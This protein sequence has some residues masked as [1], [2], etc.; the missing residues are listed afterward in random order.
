MSWARVLATGCGKTSYRLQ[1]EGLG[2][3]FVTDAALERV[4]SGATTWRIHGLKREALVGGESADP[5]HAELEQQTLN[6]RIV[7]V[8]A[9]VSA[10]VKPSLALAYR[11][12]ITTW[13][14]A[15]LSAS[16]TAIT[17]ESTSGLANGDIIH[18]GTEAILIGTV[19]SS[20]SLTGCTRGR[21]N[22]IAQK[23]VI[24][25]GETRANPQVTN[26]PLCIEGRRAWLFAYG[27]S[28]LT[29]DVGYGAG[30]GT[31][32]WIGVCQTDARLVG[33]LTEWEIQ[34][35]GIWAITEQALGGEIGRPMRPRGV[36][37]SAEA[38]LRYSIYQHSSATKPTFATAGTVE[39]LTG[40]FE[41][42]QDFCDAFNA[43][44]AGKF[45]GGNSLT[46][47]D[48]GDG[49]H[50]YLQYSTGTAGNERW[51]YINVNSPIDALFRSDIAEGPDGA[52]P[53]GLPTVAASSSYSLFPLATT[54]YMD[55]PTLPAAGQVPRGS[56]TGAG[57]APTLF[58]D[59]TAVTTAPATRVYLDDDVGDIQAS[60]GDSQF[61]AFDRSGNTID[62]IVHYTGVDTTDNYVSLSD[63][64]LVAGV[65]P[66]QQFVW[67]GPDQLPEFKFVHSFTQGDDL[68]DFRDTIVNGAADNGNSGTWPF[69]TVND[70]ADWSAEV[71]A[72]ARGKR[73]ATDRSFSGSET[74]SI[75]ELLTA[76]FRLLGVFPS[77]ESDGRVGVARLRSPAATEATEGTVG[78]SSVLVSRS[79]PTWE[80][81]A[82][83][84]VNT[85]IYLSGWNPRTNEHEGPTITVRDVG[86]CSLRKAT[87]ALE[88]E[89]RSSGFSDLADF[90]ALAQPVLGVFGRD[91]AVITCEAPLTAWTYTI[92][93]LVSFTYA[94]LP[95][96]NT[97][98]RGITSTAALVIGRQWNLDKGFVTLTLLVGA[99]LVAGYTPTLTISSK[100]SGSDGTTGPFVF[101]IDTADPLGTEEYYDAADTTWTRHWPTSARVAVTEWDDASPTIA[102]GTMSAITSTTCTITFDAVFAGLGA[103]L[104]ICRYA[105]FDTASLLSSQAAYCAVA[106]AGALIDFA[107]LTDIGARTF[108]A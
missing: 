99:Q 64:V 10:S 92:G 100:V 73:A 37:Y 69:I 51:A 66:A 6:I 77:V 96:W 84:S 75:R 52:H 83:G 18:I 103:S 46:A 48:A 34:V 15:E 88:V 25:D 4:G 19:A 78:A 106:D 3:E 58:R 59:P 108:A 91:Y 104:W 7:D 71:E 85:V 60:S 98:T 47:L 41:T 102:I 70:L 86:A 55:P 36:Y 95:D 107:S 68:A 53:V 44:I 29:T 49:A 26:R 21:W 61:T 31:Q 32:V 22:S 97:G 13:L 8:D 54:H 93:T 35:A 33:N 38:P 23:H 62:G 17:V 101:N 20:T 94:N 1:I 30:A 2:Y 79:A 56:Y 42:Q 82:L 11:P 39:Y 9:G 50:W 74:A 72:A 105:P 65:A 89:P 90:I 14:T 5:A 27:E 81:N 24:G 43:A 67:S 12:S 80:R 63:G 16:G 76:E 57:A 87:R 45:S 40:F 28:D